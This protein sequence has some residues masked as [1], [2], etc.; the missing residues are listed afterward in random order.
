MEVK[1]N[2]CWWATLG[3][4][5]LLELAYFLSKKALVLWENYNFPVESKDKWKT[6][7]LL[8]NNALQEISN[9]LK[10][11][12]EDFNI[13]RINKLYTLFV[14]PVLQ[15]RDGNLTLPYSVKS[16]FLSVFDILKGMQF[17]LN[18]SSAKQWFSK[19]IS[20]SLDA[21]KIS[22]LMTNDEISLLAHD[23]LLSHGKKD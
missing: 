5:D 18:Q 8:P 19:S 16:S 17:T 11:K 20:R 4:K 21:I 7:K 1:M 12:N 6:I 9:D 13:G 3:K 14:T 10:N 22:N 23:F 15:I 2:T